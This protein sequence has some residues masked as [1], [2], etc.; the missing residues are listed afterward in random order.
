MRPAA[1]RLT[2]ATIN[3]TVR[4]HCPL[5]GPY[6]HGEQIAIA[7]VRS[8][9]QGRADLLAEIAGLSLGLAAE[10]P[11]PEIAAQRMHEANLAALAGADLSQVA[12][13][14]P[15]GCRRAQ[16]AQASKG[17]SGDPTG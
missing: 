17:L 15:E 6:P 5:S 14:I 10:E 1:D 9:A 2:L 3:G 16:F 12:R 4:R 11:M 13:W 8:A 7:E